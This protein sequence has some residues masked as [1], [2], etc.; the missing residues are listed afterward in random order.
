LDFIGLQLDYEGKE[1]AKTLA[2][3]LCKADSATWKLIAK[4]MTDELTKK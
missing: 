1:D 2:E 4:A 3:K